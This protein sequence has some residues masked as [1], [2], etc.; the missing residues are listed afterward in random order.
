[1]ALSVEKFFNF[2]PACI[3]DPLP[4]VGVA[5]LRGIAPCG[6]RT[7]LPELAPEA[8]LRPSKIAVNLPGSESKDKSAFGGEE[9]VDHGEEFLHPNLN[10]APNLAA[11]ISQD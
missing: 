10:L 2:P 8:I 6:V 5:K 9:H 11:L 3:L 7:F 1:V 4:C